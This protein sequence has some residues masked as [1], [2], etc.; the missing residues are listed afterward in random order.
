MYEPCAARSRNQFLV[1]EQVFFCILARLHEP[2]SIWR[3]MRPGGLRGLQNR[4]GA[5]RTSRVCSI[6]T[7]LRQL[8][9]AVLA[10]GAFCWLAAETYCIQ[11]TRKGTSFLVLL[12]GFYSFS[13]SSN[14]VFDISRYSAERPRAS[15]HTRAS[16]PAAASSSASKRIDMPQP[17]DIARGVGIMAA[18]AC[19]APRA[20]SDA[21]AACVDPNAIT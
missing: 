9:C 3:W 21:I 5:R 8:Y 13:R 2:M 14:S 18:C 10:N 16:M 12:C 4:C 1:L 11:K 15:T 17:A 7:H 20:A 19:A 6:H